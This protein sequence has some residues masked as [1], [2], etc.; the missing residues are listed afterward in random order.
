[1]KRIALIISTLVFSCFTVSAQGSGPKLAASDIAGWTIEKPDTYNDKQLFGYI[2]GGAELYLE[3]GFKVVTALRCQKGKLEFV[4]DIY[5]MASPAAA[6]GIWSISR[7]NCAGT[8]PG[9]MWS[10]VT[11]NQILFTRGTFLVNITMYDKSDETKQSARKAA[12][13]LLK[14]IAGKDYTPPA[15]ITAGP[16]ARYQKDLRLLQGP[17]AVQGSLS[18]WGEY[19]EGVQ[20]FDLHHVS[21]G[22][23]KSATEAGLLHFKSPRDI[24]RFFTA[25]GFTKDAVRLKWGFNAGKTRAMKLLDATTVWFLD[26]GTEIERLTKSL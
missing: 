24:E 14:R 6:F 21:I 9:A 17:L 11:E 22:K 12:T 20:R 26:G 18:D 25:T 1:M 23:G 8:L 3:Y 4:A 19:L 10:C 5:E 15:Q 16:M 13:A 7:R 2:N